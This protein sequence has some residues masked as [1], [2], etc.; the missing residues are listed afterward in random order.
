MSNRRLTD[1]L[2]SDE[3]SLSC[4]DTKATDNNEVVKVSNATLTWDRVQS[5]PTVH[6]LNFN[7]KKGQLVCIVGR[8]GHG[9]SSCLQALLGE[10]DKLHGYVGLRG[11]VSYVPQQPWMQNQT[12]RQNITFGKTFDEYFYNRVLDAC[13]LF[14]DLCTL[15]LGDMTEIG[16]K[17]INLSGGQKARISLAR[18]VYQNYDVYLLD[19]PMSAVDSHVAAQLFSSVIGPHGMLRNKT[20]ILVT[21][22]LSFLKHSDHIYVMK[23]GRIDREGTYNELMQS[24]A[25]EP[26]LEECETEE[27]QKR[28]VEE[29]KNE[30]EEDEVYVDMSDYDNSLTESP[31]IDAILGAS[32]ATTVSGIVGRRHGSTSTSMKHRRPRHST[33]KNSF[34]TVVDMCGRHLTS[35]EKVETGK[36]KVDTY[37][38]YF[39]AMGLLLSV[40]FISG[41][42]L[43][44]IV[45]MIRNLWLTNWS[46]YNTRITNDTERRQSIGIRLGVYTIFGFSEVLLLFVGIVSLLYGA[47][48]ASRNLHSPLLHSIFRA[49]MSFFDMTPFGRILNRIGKDI[50]TVDLQLPLNV[51]FFMHCILQVV[52]TLVIVMISTPVF[53]V[54]IIPLALLYLMIMKYYI[55]S[56]RQLKRLESISR[57]PIYSHLSESIQGASTIRSYRLVERFSKVLEEK[58]DSH[59]QC[60]YFGYVA[61]RWMSVRL[62]LLGNCVVLFAAL[63]AAVAR[64]TTSSGVIGLSVSYALNITTALNLAVRQI[65]KLETN[66]VSVE[67]IMEY[68]NTSTE[69]EWKSEEGKSPPPGWPYEGKILIENYSTRYRPGLE[70]VIKSLNATIRPHEKIG[71]VGR[72]GAGK[73]S[74]TLALFRMIEPVEGRIYIDGIDITNIGLHDLRG[75]ITIIPQDPVLFS[76]TLRFNLDP[77]RRHTDEDI[78]NALEMANLKAF[79]LAQTAQL[80]HEITEGGEN[81]SV[82]QRQL[83]CL[84]RA[85]LRKT[86]VLVL[87]EA[88]AAVDLS[89]DALIQ[90]TI[91]K[92]FS[93]S[94]VLTIAHR[95]NTIMDY[96]RIIVLNEGRICEFDS[97]A[98]LLANKMSEFYSLA[99]QA[100]IVS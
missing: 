20:R 10:M 50:E 57:S 14:L 69:A 27:V 4:V 21:N 86:R 65:T 9:K 70:L 45:S 94:T 54:A 74:I 100:G 44:T 6:N 49:P 30:S 41:M 87:D 75:H 47:V 89:T 76:G 48:S 77:F 88:T 24:G 52:S 80:E 15:P 35:T 98:N 61:N 46:D 97:P 78:W 23:N 42:S 96:D 17:G 32:Y 33:V 82:G 5:E 91:R 16:E 19:D 40:L 37:L 99:K 25:L 60:R 53:G 51:Q 3:L 11:R 43:S 81:I 68:A 83:V 71:I 8:V 63:F 92:E 22:E 29:H 7:V 31:I 55:A 64:E 39:G 72:T 84:A 28:K 67:R 95:L 58:V 13:A 18:A 36:I 62:E 38:N 2:L 66:V 59:V 93:D 79:A 90:R 1:F 34:T 12:V 56:S 73:S 26:L 85:L